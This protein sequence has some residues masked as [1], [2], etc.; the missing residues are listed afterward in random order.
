MFGA[1]DWDD[2]AGR[3]LPDLAE[4]IRR[5]LGEKPAP[6]PVPPP[7]PSAGER[8]V[9]SAEN[10][11]DGR[12]LWVSNGTHAG[13][14]LVRDINPGPGDAFP[15]SFPGSFGALGDGRAL[16]GA[17]DGTGGVE[18]WITDGTAAGTRLVKDINPGRGD[19]AFD[20]VPL[21]GGRALVP[22]F[23]GVL[24]IE[25]WITDGT[26][27][28]TVLVRDVR[29]GA[30]SSDAFGFAP[31]GDGRA[32]FAANNGVRG[33][34][35]WITDGTEAGTRLVEDIRPGPEGSAPGQFVLLEDGGRTG[36]DPF[37]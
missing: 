1:V 4:A 8:F 14:R 30:A 9:F 33:E 29:P 25:P 16:F 15:F 24:G 28:G 17:S 2:L 13:T 20:I 34:E 26:E 35:V 3:L 23:D 36:F 37:G 21:G 5:F 18:L 12:E 10:G 11:S 27:A 7:P 22:A 6:T 19:G 31:F 32:L